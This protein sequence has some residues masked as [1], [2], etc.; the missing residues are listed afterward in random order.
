MIKKYKFCKK[1]F[2]LFLFFSFFL[3][4]FSTDIDFSKQNSLKDFIKV[5]GSSNSVVYIRYF[6]NYNNVLNE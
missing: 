3:Q 5:L 4:R 1:Q 6:N 2:L